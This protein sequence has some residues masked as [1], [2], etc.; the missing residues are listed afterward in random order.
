MHSPLDD[1]RHY[2]TRTSSGLYKDDPTIPIYKIHD[3][4]IEKVL[5]STGT[6]KNIIQDI[7]DFQWR[8]VQDATETFDYIYVA[9]FFK[10]KLRAD[11]SLK[12]LA[13]LEKDLK[14]LNNKVSILASETSRRVHDVH[15][16]GL[17]NKRNFI[18]EKVDILKKKLKAT[19]PKK[20]LGT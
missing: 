15:V 20:D 18:Q 17:V 14:H 11:K 1:T 7:H 4:C 2:Q 19:Y 5:A 12:L 3:S 10:L 13:R 16:E 6:K 8:M 9:K